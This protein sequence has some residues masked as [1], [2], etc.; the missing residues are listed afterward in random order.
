MK[1]ISCIGVIFVLAVFVSCGTDGTKTQEEDDGPVTV[2]TETAEPGVMR[3]YMKTD[4]NVEA[5]N[6]VKVYPNIAGKIAGNMTDLGSEVKKGDVLMYVDP[7]TPGTRFELSRITAPISGSVVSIPL[8]PGTVVTTE[9]AVAT[10]GSL[11]RLSVKS[12]IPERFVARLRIG[13][14]A[15][16]TF[17][18]YPGT[19]FKAKVRRISP[20]VDEQS[21]TKVILLTFDSPDPRINAGMFADVKLF[22][23]TYSGVF[24]VPEKALSAQGNGTSV[25]VAGPDGKAVRRSVTAGISLDSRIM[26]TAGLNAGDRVIV[27]GQTALTDGTA[28][29]SI[30]TA[31]EKV[32]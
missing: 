22:L 3:T 2:R 12:Y 5:E 20:V 21:R 11:S 15:D 16:V 32:K 1:R 17:E 23:E 18:A 30:S 4:G 24:S 13:L 6:S 7:S 14:P 9:T 10:I 27:E 31:G 25:F 19:V 8:P 29:R 28:V 26:I